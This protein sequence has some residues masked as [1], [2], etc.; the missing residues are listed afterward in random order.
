M[1]N[2][3][4]FRS[5]TVTKPTLRMRKAMAEAEVGDDVFGDDPTVNRLQEMAA[6]RF[7]KEAGLFV[8][9]GTMGNEVCVKVHTYP[10][11]EIILDELSHIY[12]AEVCGAAFNSGV[13]AR[14]LRCKNGVMD[15][16]EVEEAIRPD[17]IHYIKTALV[18]IENTHNMA[19][20]VVAPLDNMKAIRNVSQKYRIPVHLDG[21]RIFNASIASGIDVTEYA[22]YADSVMFCFSKGLSAPIGSMILGTKE[23]IEQARKYRKVFGGGMR[24]VGIIAAAAIIALEEMVDRLGEDHKNARLLA[25]GLSEMPGIDLNLDTVQ[26]NIVIIDIKESNL[27]VDF[28]LE[29]LKA[30]ETLAFSVGKNKIRFVTHKDVNQK[31]VKRLLSTMQKIFMKN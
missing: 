9:S 2:I 19:G 10:G 6:E 26:T 28:V 27:D 25:E 18:C 1:D 21:A 29:S 15:P 22:K 14:T 11:D 23:F 4:D 7:G 12:N 3:A 17:D 5:D 13:Q 16:I 31:D 30:E 8:P 24:Q 20:G